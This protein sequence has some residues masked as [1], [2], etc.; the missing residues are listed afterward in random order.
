MLESGQQRGHD[1]GEEECG[2]QPQLGAA[3]PA[4]VRGVVHVRKSLLTADGYG[5]AAR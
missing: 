2:G 5:F 4:V 1:A 3:E